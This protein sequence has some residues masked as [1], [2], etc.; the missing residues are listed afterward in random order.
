MMT[1]VFTQEIQGAASGVV[2]SLWPNWTGTWQDILTSR[3]V[4]LKALH[5]SLIAAS[6]SGAGNID[7]DV[8]IYIYP[9][10]LKAGTTANTVSRFLH[11][12]MF[13]YDESGAVPNLL[14]LDRFAALNM[15]LPP[16][17]YL[18]VKKT[19]TAETSC[20]GS[21]NGIVEWEPPNEYD[22]QDIKEQAYAAPVDLWDIL[23]VPGLP[24]VVKA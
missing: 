14:C 8:G 23:R 7:A 12:R 10:Q 4:I 9:V 24:E 21:I 20:I 2:Y 18:A 22:Y 17:S 11:Y 5:V 15:I 13:K 16:G 6:A 1:S 19:H 3:K